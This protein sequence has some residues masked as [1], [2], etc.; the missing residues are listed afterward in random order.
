MYFQA[1][2]ERLPELSRL[3][4]FKPGMMIDFTSTHALEK[5]D[6][7]EQISRNGVTERMDERD[8]QKVGFFDVKEGAGLVYRIYSQIKSFKMEGAGFFRNPW[9]FIQDSIDKV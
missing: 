7:K 6:R 9:K 4:W 5:A 1:H 2:L 8:M 3:D